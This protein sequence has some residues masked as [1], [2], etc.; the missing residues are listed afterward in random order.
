MEGPFTVEIKC[1][2]SGGTEFMLFQNS[3]LSYEN[4]VL[5]QAAVANAFLDLGRQAVE[6]HKA[7]GKPA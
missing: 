3:Q 4:L 5:V 2:D 7:R 6:L 1:S